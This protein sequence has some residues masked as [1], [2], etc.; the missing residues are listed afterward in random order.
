MKHEIKLK[1]DAKIVRQRPYRLSPEK[2]R[3]LDVQIQ[4]LLQAKVIVE[5]DSPW[6]SPVVM[7]KKRN[8]A[9][10]GSDLWRTCIDYRALNA[11]TQKDTGY[12]AMPT[13]DDLYDSISRQ[14][15]QW[16]SSLDMLSGYYQIE[17]EQKSQD[18]TTFNRGK[19]SYKFLRCPFG[20]SS[21]PFSYSRAMHAVLSR[22]GQTFVWF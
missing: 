8:K 16:M 22:L 1:P 19:G 5:S 18:Y 4:D 14:R 20:L 2:Q 21:A 17:I 7:I 15:P 13:F 12:F 6:Q 9:P 10:D 11:M 3:A